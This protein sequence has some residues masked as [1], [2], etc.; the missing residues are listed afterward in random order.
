MDQ[1]RDLGEHLAR[2]KI[3]L[4]DLQ[5]Y[6]R[7][8]EMVLDKRYFRDGPL[9]GRTFAVNFPYKIA[10]SFKRT[11]DEAVEFLHCNFR[12]FVLAELGC[13]A[14]LQR[15]C[16]ECIQAYCSGSAGASQERISEIDWDPEPLNRH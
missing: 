9:K 2:H 6:L 16:T 7:F 1:Y 12:K 14:V 3:K 10:Q 11:C 8:R 5:A 4:T 15:F 13:R